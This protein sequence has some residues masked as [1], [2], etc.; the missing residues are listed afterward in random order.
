MAPVLEAGLAFALGIAAGL[1]KQ[2]PRWVW[3]VALGLSVGWLLWLHRKQ[4]DGDR[5]RACCLLLIFF[6][7]GL[8]ASVTTTAQQRLESL[9]DQNVTLTGWIVPGSVR[10]PRPGSCAF[11][12]EEERGKVRV[13]VRKA[14]NFQP[15]QGK[16]QVQGIFRAPDGFYNPGQLD[17]EIRAAIA[18]EGG[19]LQTEGRLC[20]VLD[21][22]PRWP[23]RLFALG[24]TLRRQLRRGLSPE[25][26][27]L[28]EGML[29]GGSNGIA[30]ERLRLF[31]R[32][33]LSHLLSVSGSHVAL[34]LGLF[35]GGA[36]LL[37][38][39][40][41]AGAL[42]VAILLLAYGMLCGLR[43][44]VCRA[45]LLGLGALWGRAN[46]KRA[47]STAFLGLGLLLL[48][49]WRPWWIWDPGFQLSFAAAGGL[50][51]LR[52]PLEKKLAA[53]LPLSLAR[54]L[55]VPLA[56]QALGLPFLVHHFHM[57]SLFSLLANVLLVPL[58][59]F[60]LTCSALGAVLGALGFTIPGRLCLL[61]AGQLLGLSLWGGER[62]CRLP[63]T[64]WVTGQVP[65]WIW[66]LYGLLL[67]AVLELGW[68]R[69][70]RFHLRRAGILV[71][72]LA[73]CT[74]LGLYHFRPRPFTAYFLDVGQGDCAVVV[75]PEKQVLVFDTGGLTGRFDTGERI[76]VPFLRYLGISR[77]DA[78]F[79]SHGHHDHA[80]G[81]AG[82]LRWLPVEALYLPGETPPGEDVERAL[83]L[84]SAGK[85]GC[86]VHLLEKGQT[87][88]RKD[89]LIQV[90]EAPRVEG[91]G[92]TGNETSAI[93]RLS[94]NR[95]SLLFTG[96]A[97]A[98]VEEAAARQPIQ[99]DVLKLSHHGSR[100]SS[101]DVFLAAVQPRLAVGSMGRRNRFGHPHT[102]TLEKLELHRIPLVRTDLG[103]AVKIVFDGEIPLWYSY[104][105]Q[106][107]S[108]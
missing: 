3:V 42:L 68:F 104:R 89:C 81:L 27:A 9:V 72:G 71:S 29:L 88:R 35:A 44:S 75:T 76:L 4:P 96:D 52:R 28:L 58:L 1:G 61:G 73:L 45:L 54:G 34:L 10:T 79:L 100:T 14:V 13:Y 62:L 59:S 23:D 97:P 65:F 46:R 25:D 21:A 77:V 50:L 43:A 20:R 67:L 49:T 103:G 85:T 108:F 5:W 82:L 66:P 64:H 17:P 6:L 84:L 90:I 51:L 55:S 26:S 101:M 99:S 94:C 53:F 19:S 8:R 41:K 40:R 31:T 95:H 74:V 22:S 69:P 16:V 102:E 12:L 86:R 87:I 105:W 18:G 60:C 24:E 36:A 47:S 107:D 57:L 32:C 33:G 92:K 39:P 91:E 11:L 106:R 38:L 78:V 56:A 93:V 30:P 37:R 2:L 70:G 63:G 98:E 80:G 48:L 15:R 7:G 83:R